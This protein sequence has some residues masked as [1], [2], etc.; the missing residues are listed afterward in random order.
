M[1][2]SVNNY[3][4]KFDNELKTHSFLNCLIL[5]P[6]IALVFL[7]VSYTLYFMILMKLYPSYGHNSPF[8]DITSS[9]EGTRKEKTK[10]Y[11]RCVL[12]ECVRFYQGSITF[13]KVPSISLLVISSWPKLCHMAT[14]NIIEPVTSHF[15]TKYIVA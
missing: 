14:T 8:L 15:L 5:S 13:L 12:D 11:I 9:D 2:T 3:F 6:L 4:G 10:M 1:E 7:F